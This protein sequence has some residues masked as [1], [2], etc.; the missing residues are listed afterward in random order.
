MKLAVLLSGR[1]SNFLAIHH[2]IARGELDAAIVAV[3]SNRPGAPGI[4]RA[5][6]L[7]LPAHVIDHRA[8]SNP[9]KR[10]HRSRRLSAQT[11]SFVHAAFFFDDFTTASMKAM[12]RTASWTFG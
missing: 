11:S 2:A 9:I 1:G 8:F 6:E 5:R 7:G 10:R 3:I 4:V 12:P